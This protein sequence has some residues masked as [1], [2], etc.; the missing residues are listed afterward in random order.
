MPPGV[1]AQDLLHQGL[2]SQDPGLQVRDAIPGAELAVLQG[3][4]RL[5]LPETKQRVVTALHPIRS[6]GRRDG[7]RALSLYGATYARSSREGR[8]D[9]NPNGPES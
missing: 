4:L 1:L 3:F 6:F 9:S 5:Q 2:A 8:L 7:H